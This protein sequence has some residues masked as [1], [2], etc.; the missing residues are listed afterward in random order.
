[1]EVSLH[2]IKYGCHNGNWQ[3]KKKIL[4]PS[5]YTFQ[6]RIFFVRQL[7]LSTINFEWSWKDVS[8]IC[9][10]FGPVLPI[11]CNIVYAMN[12]EPTQ[13]MKTH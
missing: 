11:S 5:K 2:R 4:L 10:S 3:R 6:L 7:I 13:P 9:I 12:S 1:M 8:D